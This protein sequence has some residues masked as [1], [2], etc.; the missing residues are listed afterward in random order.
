MW[1][2][3]F[4]ISKILLE[5]FPLWTLLFFRNLFASITLI[6]IVRKFLNIKPGNKKIWG[7]ILGATF[8]GVVMNNAFFQLG[9]KY[10]L[11]TNASLIMALTPLATAFMSYLIFHVPLHWKQM[12]GIGLGFFGVSLV[13]MKG[14]VMTLIDLS[15]N[16]GDLYIVVALLCFSVSFIFIKKATDIQ[17]PPAIIALYAYSIS[18]ICYLPMVVWEQTAE[19]WSALPTSIIPW[20]MLLYVGIFPTG[21]GNM[22]W[23]RGISVLGPGACAMFMNGI[24]VVAAI[25]ALLLLNEPLKWLQ[26]IGFL[27][28]ASGVLL[29][30]Q[31]R[32]SLPVGGKNQKTSVEM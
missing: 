7:Y 12:L 15:F 23:N 6:W 30:S 16:I 25:T 21:V 9:L 14:S 17:F 2:S 5:S 8:I 3:N 1:G 11:S 13:V 20:L 22:L 19:G 31:N 32:E 4:V 27:F 10:T 29:G 28:I 26:I 24:P 18:S